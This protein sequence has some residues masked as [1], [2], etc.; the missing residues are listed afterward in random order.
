MRELLELSTYFHT[1]GYALYTVPLSGG[2]KKS[3]RYNK[4]LG[5][6]ELYKVI[7]GINISSPALNSAG[8]RVQ[9]DRF[10]SYSFCISAAGKSR[11]FVLC[12]EMNIRYYHIFFI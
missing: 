2:S 8:V 9:Y 1:S 3:I 4:K 11:T 6:F 12:S 10:L 5:S 7:V